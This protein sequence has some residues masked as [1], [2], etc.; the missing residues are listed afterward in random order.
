MTSVEENTTQEGADNIVRRKA[1]A[2]K[3]IDVLYVLSAGYQLAEDI[4]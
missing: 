4:K 3:K 2:G 1:E